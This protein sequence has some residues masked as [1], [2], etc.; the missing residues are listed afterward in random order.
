[1]GDGT[2][3]LTTNELLLKGVSCLGVSENNKLAED[4]GTG[5]E[6]GILVNSEDTLPLVGDGGRHESILPMKK[7]T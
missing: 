4:H 7:K 5:K 2:E 3:A 6:K 1:V